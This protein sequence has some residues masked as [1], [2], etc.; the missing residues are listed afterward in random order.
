MIRIALGLLVALAVTGTWATDVATKRPSEAGTPAIH[1]DADDL[2]PRG[3]GVDLVV[4]RDTDKFERNIARAAA[5]VR[6]ESIYDFVAIG[7]SRN[8][9]RQGERS[10]HVN[11]LEG[12]IR[13]IDRATAEGIT[14]RAAVAFKGDRTEFHGEGVWNV[15][16]SAR[17][18]VELIASRDAVESMQALTSGIMANFFA[19][20]LDH[21][22]TSR[23]TVIGMPTY[24]RFSDGNE[25]TGLRGWIIYRLVPEYGLSLNV[26]ARRYESS[27]NGSGAYFSPDR[28]E[29]AEIGLRLRRAF[30][31]WRVFATADVGRERINGDVEK[32]TSQLAL[33]AQRNFANDTGLGLQLVYYR[34]TDSSNNTIA[35]DRYAWRMARLFFTIPF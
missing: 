31:D 35:S 22:L 7:A 11:S 27:Q 34:A 25:Q 23:L 18:G 26:K 1:D 8:E 14:A 12:A 21:A 4:T 9:F 13:K 2:L 33:T 6:Y 32:P 15:R 24:R 16:F 17:T 28:Y 5:M 29:R 10:L 30:G 3:V 19:V 20:S